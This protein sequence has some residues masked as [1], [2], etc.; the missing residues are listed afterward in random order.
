MSIQVVLLPVFVLIALTFGLFFWMGSRR[1][2]SI[3]RGETRIKDI[4]LG[5]QNWPPH[6]TQI[7][8]AFHNQLELPVLYYVVTIFALLTRNADYMFVLMAWVFV[9][10]RL[11]H[12]YIFVTS[13]HVPNRF[14]AYV[15][16]AVILLLIWVILAARVLSVL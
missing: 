14:T 6:A 1:I 7:A 11:V 5:Q 15:V 4:A 3:R 12:A 8:N 13:N 16:G 10:S 9:A 2:A